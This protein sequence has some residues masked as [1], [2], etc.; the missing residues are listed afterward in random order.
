MRET[1]ETDKIA[2]QAKPAA[3]IDELIAELCPDGVE[4]RNL[5][6][7]A[8]FN[9]GQ[10]ITAKAAVNGGIPVV[11]GGQKPAYYHN[12]S[13]RPA[14]TIAVAGS[15]AYAGYVSMWDIPIWLSDTFSI[16]PNDEHELSTAFLYQCLKLNQ[17]WIYAKKKGSG[18]PHVHGTDISRLEIPV[19]PIEVQREIV[20]ILDTFT[21]LTTELTCR[22]QQYEYYRDR[23][24]SAETLAAMDGKPVEMKRLGDVL[25]YEQPTKYLVSS[26]DYSD[27]YATPRLNGGKDICSRMHVGNGRHL[28]SKQEEPSHHLR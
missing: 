19:P 12:V 5:Y 11:A 2:A 17:N 4:Y 8:H 13:N 10:V 14:G 28:S 18:V 6:D 21:E 15:G 16:T 9:R 23:L 25:N 24:L 7:I 26:K 22:R 20:H 1:P 27:D 3:K